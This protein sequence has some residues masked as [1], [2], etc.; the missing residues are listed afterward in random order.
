[1]AYHD[2][3]SKMR[4]LQD[5][6]TSAPDSVNLQV[7]PKIPDQIAK[8]QGGHLA[9]VLETLNGFKDKYGHWPTKL[10]LPP[11]A[12][13]SLREKHLTHPAFKILQSKLNLIVG[14]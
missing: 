10:R 2:F 12:L 14:E 9:R 1:P 8:Q 13:E 7:E 6:T 4:K 5:Q 11:L 3:W